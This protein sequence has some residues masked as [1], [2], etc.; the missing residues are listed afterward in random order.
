MEPNSSNTLLV[1]Y[2]HEISPGKN[3]PQSNNLI[4]IYNFQIINLSIIFPPGAGGYRFRA[5]SLFCFPAL[6]A[7]RCSFMVKNI[8]II[9]LRHCGNPKRCLTIP[10]R[11]SLAVLIFF[12]L[13][14]RYRR[15]F[16]ACGTV[17]GEKVPSRL[18]FT[19]FH[20]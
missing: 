19:P 20:Q 12:L 6:L 9:G 17:R 14:A 8:G 7:V 16:P 11:R 5:F 15:V 2:S 1:C 4:I 3:P 13:P 10:R 18:F